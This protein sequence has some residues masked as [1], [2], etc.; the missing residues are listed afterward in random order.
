MVVESLKIKNAS[1]YFWNDIVYLD[2]FDVKLVS[3]LGENQEL[4]LIF[5]ISG[6]FQINLNIILTA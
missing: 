6:M 5:I 1:Y 4:M 2:D 3:Y